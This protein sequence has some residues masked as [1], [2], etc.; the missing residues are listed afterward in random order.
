MFPEFFPPYSTPYSI[1]STLH[2][3]NMFFR[4]TNVYLMDNL[5]FLDAKE[6]EW[7][8]VTIEKL[9]FEQPLKSR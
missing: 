7:Q 4:V 6:H 9:L 8:K 3:Q 2:E 1:I 5:V